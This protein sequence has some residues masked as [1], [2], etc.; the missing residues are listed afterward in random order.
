MY[1]KTFLLCRRQL[2][3]K[4]VYFQIVYFLF[5]AECRNPTLYDKLN[6]EAKN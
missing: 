1:S 3:H 2:T 5:V 4:N 6:A